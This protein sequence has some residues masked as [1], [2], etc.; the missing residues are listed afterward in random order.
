[1]GSFDFISLQVLDEGRAKRVISDTTN[2]RNGWSLPGG[3]HGLVG[4]LAPRDNSKIFAADGFTGRRESRRADD[5]IGVQASDNND[6][7]HGVY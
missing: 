1:M 4:T 2:H 5:Q 6:I 7:G 3:S